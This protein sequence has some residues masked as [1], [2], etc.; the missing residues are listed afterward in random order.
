MGWPVTGLWMQAL[1]SPHTLRWIVSAVRDGRVLAENL[2]VEDVQ[3]TESVDGGQVTREFKA[4]IS[5]ATQELMSADPLSPLAPWGQRLQVRAELSIGASYAEMIPFGEFRIESADGDRAT[6]TLQ[7]NGAWLFGG[8]KPQVTCR[9]M[10]QQPADEPFTV[11]VQ[12]QVD[13][14]GNP[15]TVR[16]EMAR[17]LAGTGLALSPH[18]TTGATVPWGTDYGDKR[19]DALLALAGVAGDTMVLTMDRA[20]RVDLVDS[21]V[22]TGT[23]WTFTPGADVQVAWNPSADRT[24]IHNGV[25]VRG[26]GDDQYGVRGTATLDSGPLAWGGPFG[27]VPDIVTDSTIYSNAAATAAAKKKMAAGSRVAQIVVTAPANPACSVLDT[28]RIPTD[29]RTMTGLIQSLDLDDQQMKA[30]V[31]VPWEQVWVL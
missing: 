24:G 17:V 22:G 20:G 27:R 29:G 12:R 18:I 7:S 5:D 25:L 14:A 26:A 28:A 9:D 11:P 19:L 16:A 21:A 15:P 30:T 23:T 1:Q 4:T 10:L 13:A 2:E 8:Q 6:A 31:A 3:P